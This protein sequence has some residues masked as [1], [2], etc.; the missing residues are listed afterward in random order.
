MILSTSP[1]LSKHRPEVTT[2]Q[3]LNTNVTNV[4]KHFPSD[5]RLVV[6]AA[7]ANPG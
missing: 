3:Y 4:V 1:P 5:S 2:P 6:V 7:N